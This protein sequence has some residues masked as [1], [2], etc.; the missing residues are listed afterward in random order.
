M[1]RGGR[2]IIYVHREDWAKEVVFGRLQPPAV[3]DC[4][5][6]LAK[7]VQDAFEKKTGQRFQGLGQALSATRKRLD[8]KA[9]K[10]VRGLHEAV[11]FIRHLTDFGE[12]AVL[13]SLSLAVANISVDGEQEDRSAAALVASLADPQRRR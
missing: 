11:C 12:A 4:V 10:T 5:Q 13:S 8:K 9:A 2:E 6:R 1:I 7:N 3:E